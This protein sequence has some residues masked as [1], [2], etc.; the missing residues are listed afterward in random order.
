[1][2]KSD[3]MYLAC[4]I[5]DHKQVAQLL[6]LDTKHAK[7]NET[8]YRNSPL[9]YAVRRELFYY[10]TPGHYQCIILLLEA[11]ADPFQNQQEYVSLKVF[12]TPFYTAIANHNLA[13]IRLMLWYNPDYENIYNIVNDHPVTTVD[14]AKWV[15]D[16]H[17]GFSECIADTAKS[18]RCVLKHKVD[19]T[20]FITQMNYPAAANEYEQAGAIYAAQAH[21]EID[22]PYYPQARYTGKA[23]DAPPEAYRPVLINYYQQKQ[24]ECLA[25][26]YIYYQK[27]HE[28]LMKTP[29]LAPPFKQYHVEVLDRFLTLHRILKEGFDRA[30]TFYQTLKIEAPEFFLA[31]HKTV[32]ENDPKIL[33]LLTQLA[34]LRSKM[35][36]SSLR[37][38][39]LPI[40]P[41]GIMDLM[42]RVVSEADAID[43]TE[44]TFDDERATLLAENENARRGS[45]GSSGSESSSGSSI[46]SV[47]TPW[48]WAT[49]FKNPFAA[50]RDVAAKKDL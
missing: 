47:S 50:D 21:L 27:I 7:I 4:S 1:M 48:N 2:Y 40:A 16:I 38:A 18:A 13:A 44:I 10:Y 8:F 20:T 9:F 43:I 36:L 11:G 5:G 19:A 26:A 12:S 49:A 39:S 15:D 22:L 42:P 24:L 37:T 6:R 32:K 23:P 46:S 29:A 33:P 17:P 14:R 45:G 41:E 34:G 30:L 25:Q 28:I 31:L 35:D 3:K